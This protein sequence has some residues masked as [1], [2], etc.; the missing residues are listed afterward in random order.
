MK[1]TGYSRLITLTSEK[2]YFSY[3]NTQR[4]LQGLSVGKSSV[5]ICS[6]LSGRA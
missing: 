4:E 6:A 2:W 1:T 5:K 3:K